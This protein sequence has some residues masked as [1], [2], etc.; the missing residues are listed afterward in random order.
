M[1]M[2]MTKMG[3]LIANI[4]MIFVICIALM[5]NATVAQVNATDIE[6]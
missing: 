5:K 3:A 2:Q 6:E 4:C 1:V